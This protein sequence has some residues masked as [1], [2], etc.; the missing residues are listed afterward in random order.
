MTH[1]KPLSF[2]VKSSIHKPLVK[3]LVLFLLPFSVN[4]LT[5]SEFIQSLLDNHTF[6]EKEQINLTIKKI[7]MDGDR[8]NY[9]DWDWTIGGELGR[10]SKHRNKENNTSSY[11]YAKSTSQLVRKISSDLSKKF[12]SNGSELIISYDKSLPIKNE[13]MHDKDGYQGDDNTTEYLDDLNISWTLPLLKNKDGVLDQK[14]YDLAVL[15]YEDEKLVLAEAKEDFVEEK[16]MIFLDWISYDAQTKIVKNRLKH[17][18]QILA[19]IKQQS[20]SK[21][22]V[23]V[24]QRSINKTQR[25]LLEL[26]SKLK[27][28][29]RS[30]SIFL[31]GVNLNKTPLEIEWGTRANLVKD[32]NN[33]CKQSIRDIKRI[34]IEQLKNK[35]TVKSYQNSQLPDFDFTISAS[36]DDNKGNYSTYSKSSEMEY[37]AK[38]ELSYP[39]SGNISNQVYLRKYRLRGRQL[40]LRYADKFDDFIADSQKLTTELK[41][42]I[43]QLDLY[44]V[45]INESE[46]SKTQNELD[47]FLEGSGN[48]RFVIND[49][50]DYQELLLDQ[51]D[52]AINYHKN[53][54]QYDSL[55]DRLLLSSE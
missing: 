14:T 9:A 27:A 46:T 3:F 31:K 28:E 12:L 43:K 53:R 16:L 19:V 8:A 29:E 41:Q 33:Y 52:A 51:V 10:I 39:L 11:D 40:E 15:D 48:I 50:D 30:L 18:T 32:L 4:A 7:E 35:R 5:E 34:E 26:E 20:N 22:S 42:G 24:L 23:L 55:M 17:S 13:E 47:A 54:I 2:F 21:N 45:Q 37:E 25:L 36:R 6:F 1:K 49:Q 44:R 38:I